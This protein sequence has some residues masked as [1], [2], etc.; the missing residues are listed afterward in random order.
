M[1]EKMHVHKCSTFT[2]YKILI[3]LP[4]I[5]FKAVNFN[6]TCSFMYE[7]ECQS[8]CAYTSAL[9]LYT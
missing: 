2:E 5:L 6:Q 8:N 1:L 7:F 3:I 9:L 4:R